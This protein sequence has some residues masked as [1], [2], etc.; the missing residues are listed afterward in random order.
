[1]SS[2]G[3]N[4]TLQALLALER[5]PICRNPFDMAPFNGNTFQCVKLKKALKILDDIP[6]LG[7]PIGVSE[8]LIRKWERFLED[9][10]TSSLSL[11]DIRNLCWEPRVALKPEFL[12][13]ILKKERSLS[14]S[15][16]QG[17]MFSYHSEYQKAAGDAKIEGILTKFI[18]DRGQLVSSLGPWRAELASLVGAKAVE[19]MA[20]RITLPGVTFSESF[21]A[22]RIYP[23]TFFASQAANLSLLNYVETF[24]TLTPEAVEHFYKFVITA[25]PI[26]RETFKTAISRLILQPIHQEDEELRRQ[27]LA[28]VMTVSGLRDPRIHMEGWLG[29]DE[30]AKQRVIQWLSSQEIDFFFGLLIGRTDRHGRRAF[31]MEYVSRIYR[32]RALLCPRDRDTYRAQLRELQERGTSYANLKSAI[33]SAFI[34]DFDQIVVV[35]FSTVGCVYIYDRAD[36]LTIMSDFWIDEFNSDRLKRRSL[37][38]D[39][40]SHTA[41]WQQKVRNILSRYGVR[42]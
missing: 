34:L 6:A 29:I 30:K 23:N 42:R 9:G 28:Y 39:Y 15:A 19:V 20:S 10:V 1:M 21:E 8:D 3:L 18:S 33:S 36:F 7:G 37:A 17:L 11:R 5:L 41:D 26:E 12:A 40:I 2:S 31:W 32:S 22:Q 27:L 38:I 14:T 24:P 4:E 35:E 25:P 13:L 16:L